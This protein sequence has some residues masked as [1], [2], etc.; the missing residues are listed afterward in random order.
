MISTLIFDSQ[1]TLVD[2]YAIA[3][4]IEPYVFESHLAQDIAQDW[5]FHQKWGMFY[6]TLADNF[7]PL[8]QLNL[9]CLRWALEKHHVDLPEAAIQDIAAQYDK[10]RAYPDTL[11]ALKSMKEQGLTLKIVANPSK[12]MIEGHSRYSGTIK[13]LDEI[14]SNGDEVR[15]F[16]PHPNVYQLGIDRAG[17][18]KDQILW[19]TGHFWEIT[20]AVRQGLKCAWVNRA[21]QPRLQIG[22]TP[23]YTVKHLGELA[24]LLNKERKKIPVTA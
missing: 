3:D 5:R 13:Y 1:G 22:I 6:T 7:I 11:A 15:A 20:G 12:E 23:T 24:E 19:V 10:L 8:P 21:R 14:I 2:N 16:K 17:C 4:V 18:P 9:A